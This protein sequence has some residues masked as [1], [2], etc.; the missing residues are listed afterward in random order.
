MITSSIQAR[1]KVTHG[2]HR[3]GAY[4][5]SGSGAGEDGNFAR[6]VNNESDQYQIEREDRFDH[7]SHAVCHSRSWHNRRYLCLGRRQPATENNINQSVL[8]ALLEVIEYSIEYLIEKSS[9][10]SISSSRNR[11]IEYSIDNLIEKSSTRSISSSRYR[12]RDR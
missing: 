10:R 5:E 2:R 11:E 1:Y 8:T 6:I 4:W 3:S 9:T 7:Q 12:I